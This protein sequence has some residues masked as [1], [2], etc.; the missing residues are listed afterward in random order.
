MSPRVAL[1]KDVYF[2]SPRA[3]RRLG[4]RAFCGRGARIVTGYRTIHRA[5]ELTFRLFS[6]LFAKAACARRKV[7]ELGELG[8]ACRSS[9][10]L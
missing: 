9:Q 3:T 4:G 8:Q 5:M 7:L 2:R 6:T 1:A 10:R